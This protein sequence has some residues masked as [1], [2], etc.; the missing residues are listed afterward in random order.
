MKYEEE[1]EEDELMDMVQIEHGNRKSDHLVSKYFFVL[2]LKI[3]FKY[4]IQNKN[5]PK[6]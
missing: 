5:D 6:K 2:K 1:K 3:L 4:F